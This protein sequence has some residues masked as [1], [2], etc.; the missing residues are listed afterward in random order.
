MSTFPPPQ[1]ET[2]QP[3]N[4]IER[5][6]AAKRLKSAWT[7]MIISIGFS[8][9]L[10]AYLAWR[11]SYTYSNPALRGNST[12]LLIICAVVLAR[13]AWNGYRLFNKWKALKAAQEHHR[14][15]N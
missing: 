4:A 10:L 12:A 11:I 15:F 2:F 13:L 3:D 6:A 7:S 1:S 5:A 14:S 8:L 9:L